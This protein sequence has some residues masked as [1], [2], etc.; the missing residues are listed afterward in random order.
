VISSVAGEKSRAGNIHIKGEM[1]K[2][3]VDIYHVDN[4]IYNWDSFSKR[5]LVIDDAQSNSTRVLIS[6]LD[7][8]SNF[9]FKSI[10]EISLQGFEKVAG[11]RCAVI[12]C[13]PGVENELLEILWKDFVYKIR[14][15]MDDRVIREATLSATSKNNPGTS[16]SLKVSFTDYNQDISIKKP[17]VH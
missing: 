17:D 5:W 10:G 16:L 2:T 7:P 15:D 9:N 4:T 13:K 12:Y 11:R 14:V 6:E 3:P 8:L 1:V